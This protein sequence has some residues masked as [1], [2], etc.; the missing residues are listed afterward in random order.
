[1][2]RCPNCPHADK[3]YCHGEDEPGAC[4]AEGQDAAPFLHH[5]TLWECSQRG[6]PAN[7]NG[8]RERPGMSRYDLIAPGGTLDLSPAH[9]GRVAKKPWDYRVTATLAHLNTPETLEVVIELLRLQTERPYIL[10]VDTGSD[11]DVCRRL[12]TLRA[13]D[14]EIH[15]LRSHGWE[16][17]SEPVAAACDMA[18]ALC[19]TEH[20]YF[21]HADCFPRRRTLLAHMLV[22]CDASFPLVGY[23]MTD[24]SAR[25]IG[26]LMGHA[27]D[28]EFVRNNSTDNWEWMVGHNCLMLHLPT[29]FK[30]G[31]RWGFTYANQTGVRPEPF[32]D[33]ESNLNWAF[34]NA[35]IPAVLI[36]CEK[37]YSRTRDEN[38][39]HPRSYGSARLYG[40]VG[41]G[42]FQA[43]IN[44]WMNDALTEG[45]ARI[46]R[47][48][49]EDFWTPDLDEQPPVSDAYVLATSLAIPP[50]VV[51]D[52]RLLDLLW[53]RDE[54]EF[55]ADPYQR[56]KAIRC[57]SAYIAREPDDLRRAMLCGAPCIVPESTPGYHQ[58]L[59]G[60]VLGCGPEPEDVRD[61]IEYL[62][63]NPG[64]A[65]L[66]GLKAAEAAR[67]IDWD[68]LAKPR[69][70]KGCASCH[71]APT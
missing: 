54:P 52:I 57:C 34:R 28:S 39:D 61:A 11:E 17:P 71:K 47:W 5:K 33:T 68:R 40:H 51:G 56:R 21:T 48:K 70:D 38:I 19:R 27:E 42:E 41:G 9:L 23:Q 8:T 67:T 59:E 35:D 24:R 15:Y 25:E 12:E 58:H 50:P 14:V 10:I 36:G 16:H 45:R 29:A 7:P 62:L 64:E 53:V 46:E 63:A 1:M 4:P 20:M 2:P 30:I 6:W 66:L 32:H 13:E 44:G 37:N 69:V 22:Q 55:L 65:V 3:P 18:M 49:D 31:A 26:R 43:R 60:Y